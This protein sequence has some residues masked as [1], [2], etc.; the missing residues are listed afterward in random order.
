MW[1][2][3]RI[4]A[5]W[6]WAVLAYG[7]A[8]AVSAN[9][10]APIH[11][12]TVANDRNVAV[13]IGPAA[14]KVEAF[15]GGELCGYLKKLFGIEVQPTTSVPDS[16]ATVFLVGSPATNPA[17]KQATIHQPFPKV[18]DQGIV[19]RRTPFLHRTAVLVGG[20]SPTAT[21]WAVYEIAQR[22]GVQYLLH[23]DVL[24]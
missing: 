21:L 11:G 14:P 20:G 2:P 8:V 15:A 12:Q 1:K 3:K 4:S 10:S 18:D 7:F 6:P 9:A 16:A 13:V 5:K 24:H 19:L 17:V 23:G 22:W